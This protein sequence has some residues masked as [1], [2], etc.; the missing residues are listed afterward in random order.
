MESYAADGCSLPAFKPRR[1]DVGLPKPLVLV[2][3]E[4][5]QGRHHDHDTFQEQP[6]W[7]GESYSEGSGPRGSE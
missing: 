4:C 5:D 7:G 2:L 3:H 6:W 1:I